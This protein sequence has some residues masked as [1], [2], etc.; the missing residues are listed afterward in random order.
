MKRNGA[1]LVIAVVVVVAFVGW[2]LLTAPAPS[3][4]RLLTVSFLGFSNA[5]PFLGAPEEVRSVRAV[6]QVTNHTALRMGYQIQAHGAQIGGKGSAATQAGDE[7][8]GYGTGT[9]MVPT[10][11]GS[12][13]W[14]FLVV[15]TISR[16]RPAWQQR[17]REIAK[18]LGAHPVFV[19]PARTYPQF[20]N[21][22]TTPQL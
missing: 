1:I 19:G 3:P 18:K 22:W 12:N 8:P 4:P 21:I 5:L 20:T 11:V 7:L 10:D 17:V 2:F 6:F 15:S 9:F 16:P 14:R 13:G